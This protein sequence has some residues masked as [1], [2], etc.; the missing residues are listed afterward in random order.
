M[1]V[2]LEHSTC[3]AIVLGAGGSSR[4]GTPKQLVRFRGQTLIARSINNAL[5]VGC[6][7]V[8][9]VL[10]ANHE[11][12]QQ[13]LIGLQT[14]AVSNTDW[15][16]GMGSS[17]SAG[18]NA[19]VLSDPSAEA[20]LI[21][22]CDQPLITRE[23]LLSLAQIINHRESL[24]VASEYQVAGR[25]VRGVPAIFSAQLFSELGSLRGAE[26]AKS[27]IIRHEAH[28]TFV[29]IP[30]AAFDLDTPDDYKSLRAME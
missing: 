14:V 23:N 27:V 29:E 22:L 4:L 7:P 24:V 5:A 17:I 19:L 13:E 12:I 26:G 8:F 2:H 28:A 10:G 6:S 20:V 15:A 1:G 18:M 9:T 3:A 25:M 21:T 30:E 11:E 16:E